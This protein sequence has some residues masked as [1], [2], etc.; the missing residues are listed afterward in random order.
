MD[1]QGSGDGLDGAARENLILGLI[2]EVEDLG[3][4]LEAAQ[5]GRGLGLHA[6]RVQEEERRRL[7]REIHDG[8]AQLLNSVVLRIDVCQR[9]V[10]TDPERLRD[11]LQ[12]LKALVR[13]SL[14]DVRKIIFDLR[15]MALDDLGLI[16]ALRGYLK[17]YQARSGIETDLATCGS[18]H[19]FQPTFEVAIFR[20]VQEALSN[21]E[22]H[23][24]AERVWVTME[25]LGGRVVQ[26]TVKDD[27]AGFD[28]DLV[29]SSTA[30][31]KFGLLGMRERAE[32]V[33]GT[34]TIQSA[35]GQGTELTFQFPVTE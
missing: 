35:P 8:P 28:P 26:L 25:C 5:Q 7:A 34:M 32:L 13:L 9:L 33:G 24:G 10:E 20:L 3:V 15:P 2:R 31:A 16:P 14:Q 23:A 6:I 19:R 4:Q 1:E 29:L 21:V 22:K 18:D 12:Q 11:E 30:G 17:E 27:G